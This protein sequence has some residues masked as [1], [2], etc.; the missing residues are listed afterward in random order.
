MWRTPACAIVADHRIDL[1]ARR[2]DAGEMR[3]RRQRGLGEDAL[4]RRVG[5]LARRAAG[6]VGHRDEIR[7]PA[8]R[9][10]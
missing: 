7:V 8:A 10:A 1:G 9:A 6:A 3:R 5:A 2:R 4:D